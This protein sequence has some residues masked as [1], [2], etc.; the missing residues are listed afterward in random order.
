MTLE[1]L[2]KFK[3]EDGL[4]VSVFNVG[5]KRHKQVNKAFQLAYGKRRFNEIQKV[6][7]TTGGVMGI[8]QVEPTSDL[9]LYAIMLGIK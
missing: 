6:I 8:F 2:L 5:E 3:C 7:K 1:K 9:I 4:F